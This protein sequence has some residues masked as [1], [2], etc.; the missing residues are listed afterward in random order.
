[1]SLSNLAYF[2][3]QWL[4]VAQLTVQ[5]HVNADKGLTRML[6]RVSLT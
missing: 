6:I 4:F 5:S 2:A 3:S 1:L